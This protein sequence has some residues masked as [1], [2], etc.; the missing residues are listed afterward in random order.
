V[1]FLGHVVSKGRIKVDL[2]K[3]KAIIECP[4]LINVIKIRN[5][6]SLAG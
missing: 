3:A 5:V 4:M 2:K 6:S 1:V